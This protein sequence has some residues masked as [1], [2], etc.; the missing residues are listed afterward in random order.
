M[1][2]TLLAWHSHA[3]PPHPPHINNMHMWGNTWHFSFQTCCLTWYNIFQF[4][5][6]FSLKLSKN[7]RGFFNDPPIWRCTCR[8]TQFPC[9]CEW[10]GSKHGCATIFGCI[11][12]GLVQPGPVIVIF[13]C[14]HFQTPPSWRPQWLHLSILT[15]TVSK[16]PSPLHPSQHFDLFISIYLFSWW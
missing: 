1:T 16:D 5:H 11:W 3:P 10:N 8:L 13:V 7:H 14:F 15:P 6:H 2:S 9:C 4:Y 12:S